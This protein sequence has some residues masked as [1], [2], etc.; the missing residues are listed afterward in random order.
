MRRK[1]ERMMTIHAEWIDRLEAMLK[2][3]EEVD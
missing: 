1:D 2:D 3:G